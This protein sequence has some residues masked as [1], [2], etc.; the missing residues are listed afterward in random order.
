[1]ANAQEQFGN[2]LCDRLHLVRA[3]TRATVMLNL[4]IYVVPIMATLFAVANRDLLDEW[5]LPPHLRNLAHGP[6]PT[7]VLG[8][9]RKA[10]TDFTIPFWRVFRYPLDAVIEFLGGDGILGVKR[11][12][13]FGIWITFGVVGCICLE[14]Y[15]RYRLNNLS[16]QYK[17]RERIDGELRLCVTD[18]LEDKDRKEGVACNPGLA[19]TT[20]NHL[21]AVFS[22]L[23]SF[24]MQ[25]PCAQKGPR[26]EI[27]HVKAHVI[28]AVKRVLSRVRT[29]KTI[30]WINAVAVGL[31][32]LWVATCA[33]QVIMHVAM[34]RP[35]L[36]PARKSVSV[37]FTAFTLSIAVLILATISI[38][39][40]R[41]SQ[42][43]VQI[44]ER[45]ANLR[46]T[47]M[48]CDDAETHGND[49]SRKKISEHLGEAGIML[50]EVAP[51]NQDQHYSPRLLAAGLVVASV[52]T[53]C[54]VAYQMGL[55]STSSG[56][57]T[58]HS[59]PMRKFVSS[60]DVLSRAARGLSKSINTGDHMFG[61]TGAGTDLSPQSFIE[62]L[63]RSQNK[64][65]K[66]ISAAHVIGW[67]SLLTTLS[68]ILTVLGI[69]DIYTST[70][71]MPKPEWF[72]DMG[73]PE[74]PQDFPDLDEDPVPPQA[75]RP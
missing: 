62:R 48:N 12:T 70:T 36:S 41:Y 25:Q 10:I 5:R 39:L 20:T 1:M 38:A 57:R 37:S 28:V 49:E 54:V 8:H 32:T 47:V 72:E 4:A 56:V 55:F 16:F 3:N 66:E 50:G 73:Y 44:G 58:L 11:E 69:T 63:Q 42:K 7:T 51:P 74:P 15:L 21:K 34:G 26:F 35:D 61:G 22:M 68:A 14:R 43:E 13:I 23:K 71:S 60:K 75:R 29:W 18:R 64:I 46:A 65:G 24:V 19:S 53:I 67:S 40:N 27:R 33:Q 30:Y 52:L 59:Q 31:T 6:D 9:V 2:L 17:L 45:F